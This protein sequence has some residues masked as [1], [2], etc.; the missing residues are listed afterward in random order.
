MSMVVMKRLRGFRQWFTVHIN[1]FYIIGIAAYVVVLLVTASRSKEPLSAPSPK[2]PDL[3]LAVDISVT[4]ST[5][6]I[7]ASLVLLTILGAFVAFVLAEREPSEWFR[8]CSVAAGL[9]IVA[10]MW[11]AGIAISKASNAAWSGKFDLESARYFFNLQTLLALIGILFFSIVLVVFG[12]SLRK[13]EK[14]E[15]VGIEEKL[16]K[17]AERSADVCEFLRS[18]GVESCGQDEMSHGGVSAEAGEKEEG[19]T[20]SMGSS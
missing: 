11:V 5:Q 7:T 18:A 17:I 12:E 9:S 16:E 13:Q 14:S 6:I 1:I 8:L 4:L 20:N 19:D 2:T 10:S 3:H 15:F